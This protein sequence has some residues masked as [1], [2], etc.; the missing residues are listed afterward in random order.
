MSYQIRYNDL[1]AD[2]LLV[3]RKYWEEKLKSPP[4]RILNLI[5]DKIEGLTEFPNI[6]QRL[7]DYPALRRMVVEDYIVLY[8]VDEEREA[9]KIEYIY[10][11]SRQLKKVLTREVTDKIVLDKFRG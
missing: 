5:L 9:V 8:Q 11:G 4:D 3:I 2:D 1:I 6:Y 10:H 7:E